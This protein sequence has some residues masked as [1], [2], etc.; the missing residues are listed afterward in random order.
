VDNK[1]VANSFDLNNRVASIYRVKKM[2]P[3]SMVSYGGT[4]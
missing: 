1:S 4:R 2:Q 3:R